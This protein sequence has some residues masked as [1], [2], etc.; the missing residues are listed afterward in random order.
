MFQMFKKNCK[1]RYSITNNSFFSNF[2][3]LSLAVCIE[4]LKSNLCL[5]FNIN[6]TLNI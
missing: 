5:I 1:L 3:N 4:I 2:K 6:K